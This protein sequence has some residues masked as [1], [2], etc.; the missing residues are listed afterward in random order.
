MARSSLAAR[1]LASAG[2][3]ALLADIP[4]ALNRATAE[5][6]LRTF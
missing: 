3:A 5:R 6:L 4:M 2:L 1:L